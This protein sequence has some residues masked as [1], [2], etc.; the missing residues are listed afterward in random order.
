MENNKKKK[1]KYIIFDLDGT[2][3]EKKSV[4]EYYLKKFADHEGYDFYQIH[5]SFTLA[6]TKASQDKYT[7][8]AQFWSK[9]HDIFLKDIKSNKRRLLDSLAEKAKSKAL[10]SIKPRPF[11]IDLFKKIKDSGMK[12][13]VFT[14]SHNMYESIH[15]KE[16]D[17]EY[18][19]LLI[20]KHKQL[21]LL[22]LSQFIDRLILTNKYGGFKPQKFVFESLLNDLKI[23]ANE[24]IMVGDQ[25]N[26]MGATKVDIFS[27][28]IGNDDSKYFEP[29]I[30]IK[31]FKEFTD[32]I[33][34]QECMLKYSNLVLSPCNP[35]T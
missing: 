32:I 24:C 22:G 2:L 27:V 29:N 11:L 6:Y 1:I 33:D 31:S 4:V 18:R 28:L 16:S 5:E 12:I 19:K 7:N 25:S 30:K 23:K 34:F 21:D 13:I 20:F 26:D 10:T 35:P 3:Y 9:V 8:P 17:E 14:G 15:L